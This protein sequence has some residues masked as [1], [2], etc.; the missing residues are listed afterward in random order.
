MKVLVTGAPGWLG[1][2]LVKNLVDKGFK[3]RCL[4]L[5]GLDYS[6]LEKLG[7]EI[8]IGDVTKKDTLKGIADGIDIVFHCVGI[9]HP[10]KIRQLYDLNYLGTKNMID[11]AI[12]SK[13]K[14]FVFVSSNS[15][16]GVNKNREI[17]LDESAPY[18]PYKNYGKSKML[19]EI[20][21]NKM[22]EH[23]KIDT[24]IVRPCWFYGPN[25][26][27]RQ[28]TFFNMI[29][30]GNPIIFGDGKNL[31][32]MTYIDNAVKGLIL[33]GTKKQAIGQTYWIADKKPY[34][35]IEIYKTIA[36]ILGV[37]L[38]PRFVP[39][40]VSTFFGLAD[41][42]LQAFGFYKQEFHV[43]GEMDK[44]IACSIKKAEKELGYNPRASLKQGMEESIKWCRSQGVDI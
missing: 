41:D 43:A 2:S 18:K 25:Q 38:K 40:L 28:T 42:I 33:A 36:E 1:D 19:A 14:R 32:S 13:A 24:T 7:A 30:K 27:L 22:F 26:P 12:E 44:D 34:S 8:V 5:Q 23:G 39:K 3:V 29:K 6:H 21:V 17:L 11:S 16:M 9:I 37:E 15:P 35:T 31:R 10:K 4:V 20:Y